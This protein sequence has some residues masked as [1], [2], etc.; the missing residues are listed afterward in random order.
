ML[1]ITTRRRTITVV[2]PWATRCFAVI[3]ASAY[4]VTMVWLSWAY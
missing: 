1:R 2:E 4:L 3:I